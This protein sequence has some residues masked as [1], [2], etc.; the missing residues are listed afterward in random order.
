MSE[1]VLLDPNLPCRHGQFNGGHYVEPE[2]PSYTGAV[3]PLVALPWC[4]G[5]AEVRLVREW[6][7]EVDLC[8]KTMSEE[9]CKAERAAYDDSNY[10]DGCREVWR[11]VTDE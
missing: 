11:V 4:P 1:R 9:E 3:P 2:Q 6:I 5:M 10:H 7:C 8:V